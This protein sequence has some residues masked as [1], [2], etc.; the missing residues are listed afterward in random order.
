[1]AS[2]EQESRGRERRSVVRGSGAV[3]GTW[4]LRGLSRATRGSLAVPGGILRCCR[5]VGG[6]EIDFRPV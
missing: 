3:C 6:R 1:M 2:V 5:V 4:L